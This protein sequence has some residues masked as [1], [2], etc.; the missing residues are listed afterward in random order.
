MKN[1]VY[2]F[3]RFFFSL[4]LTNRSFGTYV[5]CTGGDIKLKFILL[6]DKFYGGSGCIAI[7]ASSYIHPKKFS[8]EATNGSG[9]LETFL[10]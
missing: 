1:C 8:N 10:E 5:G 3:I 6:W 7:F 4:S 9:S 2:F